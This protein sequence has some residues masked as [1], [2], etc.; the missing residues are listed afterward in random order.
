MAPEE[1]LDWEAR[2]G[3]L[4]AAAAFVSALALLA[5]FVYRRVAIQGPSNTD[6][7]RLQTIDAESRDFILTAA[8]QAL[9]VALLAAVLWYLYRA[10]KARRPELPSVGLVLAIGGPLLS[11]AVGVV[12]QVDRINSA[13][14]LVAEGPP[15]QE[16]AADFLRGSGS[17]V[18]VALGFAAG[19]AIGFAF[20]LISLNAMR[21]GLLSRFIG[22][23]G[24]IV[25]ALYVIPL[26]GSESVVIIQL[27][28]VTALGALFLDR[29]PG[30]RGP[31]WRSVEAIP[32]PGAAEQREAMARR[33][34]EQEEAQAAQ[35]AAN[36][37]GSSP[38]TPVK[39]KRKRRR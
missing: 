4:A 21:A 10:T 38:A 37:T 25:G 33:R 5:S 36:G 26:F 20:V 16:V 18:F 6:V 15:S 14:D 19:L 13:G 9:A 7:E 27:F 39:R 35:P 32:W 24:I 2:A 34:E 8:L 28:W 12:F 29:W 1:Q 31:A 17:E 11:A 23:L 30:G 3:R 22:I